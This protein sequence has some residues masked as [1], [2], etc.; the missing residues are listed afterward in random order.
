MIDSVA[1][2]WIWL[3]FT[4]LVIASI[5]PFVVWSI[6]SGQFSRFEESSRLAL[7]SGIPEETEE[8][9]EDHHVSA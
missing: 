7:T 3:A 8:R 5:I 1:F 6:R 2:F 4:I 9:K